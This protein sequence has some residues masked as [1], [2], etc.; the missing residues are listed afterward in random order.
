MN[1]EIVT[2]PAYRAIGLKWEGTFSEI[3]PNLKNTIS[4]MKGRAGELD[5]KVNPDVQLGLSYHVIEN[6]FVHYSVFEVSEA[7]EVPDEMLEIRIPEWTYMKAGHKKGEDI[8]QTYSALHQWLFDSE[9]RAY[10]EPGVDYYDPYMPIKHEYYPADQNPDD[11]HFDIY[12]PITK[13]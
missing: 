1:Y 7:Q 4:L 6:G 9:Y 10:R 13:K 11:P 3:V 2:L 5:H 8:A 12:I